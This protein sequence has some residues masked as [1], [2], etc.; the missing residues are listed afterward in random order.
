MTGPLWDELLTGVPKGSMLGPLLFNGYI[1][2]LFYAVKYSDIC[3]FADDTTSHSSSIDIDEAISYAEHDCLLLVDN[4]M[5]LNASKCNLLVSGYKHELMLATVG[6]ALILQEV[7]AKLLGIII[8]SILVSVEGN[9]QFKN[10]F[11]SRTKNSFV[12]NKGSFVFK[13]LY[14]Y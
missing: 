6:D 3:N 4:Y 10:S 13:H 11:D 7:S 1:D 2:D 14:K 12:S 8:D 5:T 9:G